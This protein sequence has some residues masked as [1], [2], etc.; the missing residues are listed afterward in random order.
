MHEPNLTYF[1]KKELKYVIP[2][3]EVL[4]IK[5]SGFLMDSCIPDCEDCYFDQ[6]T[7][8]DDDE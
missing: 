7:P 6:E 1:M 5:V 3:A 4:T 8:G 2:D